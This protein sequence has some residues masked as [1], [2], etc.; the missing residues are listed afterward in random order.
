MF[1]A[2]SIPVSMADRYPYRQQ[3]EETARLVAGRVNTLRAGA[4]LRYSTVY[5]SRSGR[6]EDPWLGPDVCDHLRDA[7]AA[8][9]PAAVLCPIGFLVDHV[10][11]LYDLDTEAA[12]AAQAIG[13]P[14]SRAGTVGDHPRFIAMLGDVVRETTTLYR[15]G[16][17]LPI[18]PASLPAAPAR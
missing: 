5:Q 16:R 13:L 6:P 1:T 17:P 8:G 4:P 2:H 12:A 9:V 11:V 10:E 3:F 7:H 14:V 18:V 15:S